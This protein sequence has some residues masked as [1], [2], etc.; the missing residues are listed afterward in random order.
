M[1]VATDHQRKNSMSFRGRFVG[2]HLDNVP[3]R[4][5]WVP[6]VTEIGAI[7]DLI[8]QP[9]YLKKTTFICSNRRSP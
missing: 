3:T 2:D 1:K 7:T 8:V 5:A 6:A 9:R 4:F